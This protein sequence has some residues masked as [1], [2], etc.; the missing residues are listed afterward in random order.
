MVPVAN[1]VAYSSKFPKGM[2]KYLLRE[3]LTEEVEQVVIEGLG[4]IPRSLGFSIDHLRERFQTG[5]VTQVRDQVQ[6]AVQADLNALEYHWR[7]HSP[8]FQL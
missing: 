1:L 6:R 3:V 4:D 2:G 5:V 7:T 8:G